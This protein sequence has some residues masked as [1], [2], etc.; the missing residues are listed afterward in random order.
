MSY[1]LQGLLATVRVTATIR[2][3]FFNSS[4]A[5]EAEGHEKL[6]DWC[7]ELLD[8][9]RARTEWSYSLVMTGMITSQDGCNATFQGLGA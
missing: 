3:G 7:V 1:Y 5:T 4:W 6:P 2:W 9:Y 8:F